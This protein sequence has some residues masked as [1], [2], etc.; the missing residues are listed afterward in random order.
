MKH[1]GLYPQ[2]LQQLDLVFLFG[3]S[4]SLKTALSSV[5]LKE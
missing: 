4:C 3:S 5:L 2:S 1:K